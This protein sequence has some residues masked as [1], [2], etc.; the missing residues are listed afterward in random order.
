M[1]SVINSTLRTLKNSVNQKLETYNNLVNELNSIINTPNNLFIDLSSAT[2][3]YYLEPGQVAFY[4]FTSVTSL[5]LH[6]ATVNGSY[7][8]MHTMINMPLARTVNNGGIYLYPNNTTSYTDMY[9][10]ENWVTN[11]GT[12]GMYLSNF[13]YFFISNGFGDVVSYITNF[14]TYKNVKV[15]GDAGVYNTVGAPFIQVMTSTWY[16]TT[17]SWTS[18]GTIN[19]GNPPPATGYIIIKRIF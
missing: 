8:E 18:L 3:D 7:Y 16:D 17:T 5:S 15:I 14:T 12:Y 6:I 1:P 19:F 2:A 10:L 9:F 11:S 13:N 4:S